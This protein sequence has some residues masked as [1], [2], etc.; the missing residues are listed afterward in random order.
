MI[1]MIGVNLLFLLMKII[2]QK[3]VPM[4]QCLPE[5]CTCRAD[6]DLDQE[7][8]GLGCV[9]YYMTVMRRRGHASY[10]E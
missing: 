3:T 7:R 5:R 9:M 10:V 8:R 4:I 2:S 1:R 6:Y